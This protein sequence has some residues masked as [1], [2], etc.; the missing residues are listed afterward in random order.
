MGFGKERHPDKG[1]QKFINLITQAMKWE[2]LLFS[3]SFLC[4]GMLAITL[5]RNVCT[6]ADQNYFQ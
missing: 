6:F 2:F 1:R 3:S 5:S 4:E